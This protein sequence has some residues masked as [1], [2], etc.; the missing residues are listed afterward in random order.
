MTIYRLVDHGYPFKK[1]MRGREW[2][3]R[4]CRHAEGGF[5]GIIGKDSLR[6]PSEVEAFE[7]IVARAMGFS[8]AA[9]LR[10]KNARVRGAKRMIARAADAAMD[11]YYATGNIEPAANMLEH[12]A[13]APALV[14]ALA[15]SLRRPRP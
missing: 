2:V 15:R 13:L 11:E 5:L 14:S 1:I 12:P 9:A 10:A 6:A 4:V 8:C 7:E 3:G